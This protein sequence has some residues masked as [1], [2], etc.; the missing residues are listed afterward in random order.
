MVDYIFYIP[1]ELITGYWNVFSLG[2][3]RFISWGCYNFA[4]PATFYGV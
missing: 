2:S 1:G 4:A 3:G